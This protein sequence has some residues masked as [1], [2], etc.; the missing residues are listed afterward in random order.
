MKSISLKELLR[1]NK[2]LPIEKSMPIVVEGL[3]SAYVVVAVQEPTPGDV[4][5]MMATDKNGKLWLYC[6]TDEEEFS[7]AFPKGGQ[8]ADM[9]FSDLFETIEPEQRFGGVFLNS[10]TDTQYPIPREM[11]GVLK[12]FIQK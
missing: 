7:T 11:F 12:K 10:K 9:K 8:F 5:F 3:A 1:A 6:F 4:Q 2:D